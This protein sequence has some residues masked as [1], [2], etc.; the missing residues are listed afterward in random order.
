[1]EDLQSAQ[2]MVKEPLSAEVWRKHL[3]HLLH[4][5]IADNVAVDPRGH[6]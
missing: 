5:C 3:V 1:M 4:V 6:S 2:P